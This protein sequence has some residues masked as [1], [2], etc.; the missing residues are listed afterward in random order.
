M[1]MRW[2][3]RK[4]ESEMK[5]KMYHLLSAILLE[6]LHIDLNRPSKREKIS[7]RDPNES[8]RTDNIVFIIPPFN[9]LTFGVYQEHRL[10]IFYAESEEECLV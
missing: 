4:N 1:G 3:R 7:A 9:M 5:S 8:S 6:Y 2:E 10:S